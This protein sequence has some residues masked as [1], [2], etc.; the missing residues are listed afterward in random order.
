LD[1]SIYPNPVDNMLFFSIKN[2]VPKNYLVEICNM[3]GK[4]VM[5]KTYTNV[6]NL[7]VE[8]PRSKSMVSGVYVLNITDLQTKE[9]KVFKI[10][11]K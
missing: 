11:Y 3:I 4:K 6:Q 5:S 2:S 1:I 9:R 10:I 7:V 8:Y